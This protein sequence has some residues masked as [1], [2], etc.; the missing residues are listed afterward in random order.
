MSSGADLN[1]IIVA[2]DQSA[3]RDLLRSLLSREGIQVL[4]VRDGQEAV[5]LARSTL[6]KLVLL[7]VRMPHLDGLEAC[8]CIRKNLLGLHTPAHVDEVPVSRLKQNISGVVADFSL[9]STDNPTD[10]E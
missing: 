10:T 6:A 8:A 1:S 9:C 5:E 7:D 3:W 2:D 4:L